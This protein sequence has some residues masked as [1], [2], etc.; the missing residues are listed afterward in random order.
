VLTSGE[1]A[2]EGD[3]MIDRIQDALHRAEDAADAGNLEAFRSEIIE[4]ETLLNRYGHGYRN[5]T[6]VYWQDEI[7]TVQR[8]CAE[9]FA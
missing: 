4:A 1:G 3:T 8:R 2:A 5:E 7:D 6:R 9:A